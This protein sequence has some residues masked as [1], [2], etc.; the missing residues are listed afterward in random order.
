MS[1]FREAEVAVCRC[2]SKLIIHEIRILV[3]I[4]SEV[5]FNQAK[6]S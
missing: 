3:I 4:R 6:L 2:S 5:F 1:K